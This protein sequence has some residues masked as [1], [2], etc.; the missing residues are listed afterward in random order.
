VGH[1]VIGIGVNVHTRAFPA[2]IAAH[3]TSVALVADAP[4]DRA[5]LLADVLEGL[6]RDVVV[7]LGRGLGL[8]RARLAAVD[9]LRGERVLGDHGEEGVAQGI[10]DDGRLVVLRDDGV[11]V[12]WSAGEVRLC[13]TNRSD[14][15]EVTH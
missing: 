11:L 8:V 6:D 4:P 5:T 2:D 12:R 7:T 10:N 14:D 1:L 3:G 15:Q 13:G 9:A